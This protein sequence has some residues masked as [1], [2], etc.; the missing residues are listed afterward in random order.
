[1]ENVNVAFEWKNLEDFESGSNPHEKRALIV[2]NNV[3]LL[4][5]HYKFGE[6]VKESS[7]LNLRAFSKLT[8]EV[9]IREKAIELFKNGKILNSP[10][11]RDYPNNKIN[12]IV[13]KM[14]IVSVE[15]KN[16]KLQK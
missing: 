1:M 16:C 10:K 9:Q 4:T 2:D 5:I 14:Q 7:C 15:K 12:K 13:N 6:M 11:Y 3:I 8:D